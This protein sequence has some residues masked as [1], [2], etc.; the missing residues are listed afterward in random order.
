MIARGGWVAFTALTSFAIS[1][2]TGSPP[3]TG[4]TVTDSAGIVIV[5]SSQALWTE[6][7]R[8]HLSG[9]PLA[10]IGVE[11][12]PEEYQLYRVRSAVRMDDGRIVIANHGSSELRFY[13]PTGGFLFARG[14]EGEGPGEFS[15]IGMILRLQDSLYLFDFHLMRVTVYSGSGEFGRSFRVQPTPDGALPLPEGVLASRHLL[16]RRSP[17]DAELKT[18]FYRDTS[19]FL[20]FDL[21]GVYVDSIGRFPGS[22]DY[23]GQ[24]GDVTFS[25]D[26]PFGRRSYTATFG[27]GFY[28]GSSDSWEIEFR[29][30]DGTLQRLI[31]RPLPNPPVTSQESDEFYESLRERMTRMSSLWRGLYEQVTL[32]DTKPAYGRLLADTEGNLWV[33]EYD[34]ERRWTVFNREGRLLGTLEIEGRVRVLEIGSDY[35][36]GMWQDEVD[37]ERVFLYGLA[38]P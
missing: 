23:I 8:W 30:S 38:K 21:E 22:E 18:G 20:R 13:D 12:G 11:E 15:S 28:F 10:S 2:C 17:R 32:P 29:T 34:D 25:T 35:L 6:E 26:A 27:D 33:A 4:S 14:G 37:V 24:Q 31:R 7:S 5:E 1:A 36:L 3:D 9:E 19:L 16:A